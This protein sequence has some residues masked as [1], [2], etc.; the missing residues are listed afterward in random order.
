MSSQD[1]VTGNRFTLLSETKKKK[2]NGKNQQHKTVFSEGG[3]N[4]VSPPTASA[5]CYMVS[6]RGR[7]RA[8]SWGKPETG[9]LRQSNRGESCTERKKP[10]ESYKNPPRVFSRV[11]IGTY[12]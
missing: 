2:K 10:P 6:L 1:G 7:E 3:I 8:V 9:V 12:T 4:K 5:Y 11:L